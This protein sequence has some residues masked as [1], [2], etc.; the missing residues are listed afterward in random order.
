MG[1][2]VRSD[3][4]SLMIVGVDLHFRTVFYLVY[5][6]IACTTFSHLQ[7]STVHWVIP[8]SPE[9]FLRLLGL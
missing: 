8:K 7:L 6:L 5:H 4:L 1:S 3:L 2:P 9:Q